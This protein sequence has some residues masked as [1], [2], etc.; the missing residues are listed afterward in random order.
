MC[1]MDDQNPIKGLTP[2][3][4]FLDQTISAS[5]LTG[6]AALTIFDYPHD[7]WNE[8]ADEG[9]HAGSDAAIAEVIKRLQ[10]VLPQT[11][12]LAALGY[13]TFATMI[14]GPRFSDHRDLVIK[15][16]KHANSQVIDWKGIKLAA[17]RIVAALVMAQAPDTV[18]PTALVYVAASLVFRGAAEWQ[19]DRVLSWIHRDGNWQP[20]D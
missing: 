7:S 13:M 20:F 11:C 3:S 14:P 9:G 10:T 4:I 19:P 8:A 6:P 5:I 18:T 16:V 1:L 15:A 2:R 12:T 17:P